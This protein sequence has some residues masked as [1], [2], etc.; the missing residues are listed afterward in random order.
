MVNLGTSERYRHLKLAL[1]LDSGLLSSLM[2]KQ[3]SRLKADL[4]IADD[5]IAVYRVEESVEKAIE[6]SIIAC[7]TLVRLDVKP[8]RRLIGELRNMDLVLAFLDVE[9]SAARG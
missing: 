1:F 7:P 6:H 5:Q 8:S 9:S 3:I 4:N 2:L